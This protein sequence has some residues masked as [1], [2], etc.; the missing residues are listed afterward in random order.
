MTLLVRPL[1][2]LMRLFPNLELHFI[3][4]NAADTPPRKERRSPPLPARSGRARRLDAWPLLTEESR[5]VAAIGHEL[6]AGR[7]R[8][9]PR[10]R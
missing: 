7:E 1:T 3:H 2:E 10:P 6:V 9:R 8:T 5:M 4:G